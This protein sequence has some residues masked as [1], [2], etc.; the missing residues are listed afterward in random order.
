MTCFTRAC[1]VLS[2][3]RSR[4]PAFRLHPPTHP[5]LVP[6]VLNTFWDTYMMPIA[7]YLIAQV[8]RLGFRGVERF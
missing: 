2:S 8:S 6:M 5:G 4:D 3:P 1:F 7:F